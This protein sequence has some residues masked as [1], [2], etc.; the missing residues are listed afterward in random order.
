M[1]SEMNDTSDNGV[2][3]AAQGAGTD[4]PGVPPNILRRSLV[5]SA[6]GSIIGTFFF[7]LN[8]GPIF[9]RY[10]EFIGLKEKLGIFMAI[11]ALAGITQMFGA[12]ILQRTGRRR[13]FFFLFLL[14]NF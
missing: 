12:W 14:E 4:L 2:P 5:L 11:P 9:N 10:I 7:S 6:A 8:A 13:L 3:D 1:A